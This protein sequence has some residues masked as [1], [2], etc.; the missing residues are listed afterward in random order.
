MEMTHIGPMVSYASPDDED[1]S[2]KSSEGDDT[3]ELLGNSRRACEL[4]YVQPSLIAVLL[5]EVKVPH[6][7]V[8]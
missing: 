1:L 2:N 8:V 5:S 3:N 4:S 7:C 6:S